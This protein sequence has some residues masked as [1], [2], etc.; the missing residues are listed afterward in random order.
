MVD[1]NKS[2][3]IVL[4]HEGGYANVTHDAGGETKYGISQARYP[5]IDIKNLTLQEAKNLYFKD[6]WKRFKIDTLYNQSI[7]DFA[8]D[9]V[10]HHGKGVYILQK[11]LVKSGKP[12]TMNNIIGPQTIGALNSVSPAT[13]LK[14]AVEE[15]KNYMRAL[16]V[17]NPSQGK[18]LTGWLKRA[19]FFLP[20]AIGGGLLGILALGGI[21]WY[22][23][24]KS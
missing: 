16:V 8:L 11:A 12:V 4:K 3:E 13:Y 18:F 15:R 7:A 17:K 19:D 9:T 2:I 20:A 21:V 24:R 6:Y 5:D 10:V 1:F 22:F 23:I 14:N